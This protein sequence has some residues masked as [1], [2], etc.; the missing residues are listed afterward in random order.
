MWLARALVFGLAVVPMALAGA[1][2]G[3]G[4]KPAVGNADGLRDQALA[5]MADVSSYRTELELAEGAP[6]IW[7][8][9]KPSSYRTYVAAKDAETGKQVSFG[10]ELYVGDSIYARNC[11]DVETNCQEWKSSPRGKT[12]ISAPSPAYY[13]QWPL[14]ALE[15]AKDM[16]AS[17]KGGDFRLVGTVNPTRAVLESTKRIL[18][19]EGRSDFGREC[20]SSATA[21]Q[22][23]DGEPS[24]TPASITPQETCRDTTYSDLLAQEADDIA[25]FDEHPATIK[26]SVDKDTHLVSRIEITLPS[27]EA[28]QADAL[29]VMT[30]SKFNGVTIEAPE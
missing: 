15:M 19:Q 23:Q 9:A 24:P 8:Y 28:G 27:R 26:A 10:E 5:A 20:T 22:V 7:E 18:D 29:F 21:M 2:A 16:T 25:F 17:A 4:G 30:Y 11:D 6:L 13:P 12:V 3:A 1:C 14:V